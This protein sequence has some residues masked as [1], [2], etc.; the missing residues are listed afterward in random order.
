VHL[1]EQKQLL[2]TTLFIHLHHLVRLRLKVV[3]VAWSILSSLLVAAAVDMVVVYL[4]LE[5]ELEDIALTFLDNLLVAVLVQ[6]L[7]L[8]LSHQELIQ[9]LLVLVVLV[10]DLVIRQGARVEVL[11]HLTY[12]Q[13][14][15]LLVEV[16]EVVGV[17]RRDLL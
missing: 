10:V 17:H 7:L 9:L 13:Q 1:V 11:P 3:L 14:S 5:E 12:H 15:H 4:V 6:K 8:R 2:V 16:E